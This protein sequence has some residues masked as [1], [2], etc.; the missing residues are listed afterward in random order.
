MVEP[1]E[2]TDEFFNN[3]KNSFR[4]RIG[5]IRHNN[6]LRQLLPS[7]FVSSISFEKKKT[8]I[9]NSLKKII[10][11]VLLMIFIATCH[12]SNAQ[13]G[14]NIFT[15]KGK[16]HDSLSGQVLARVTVAL[17]KDSSKVVQTVITGEDGSFVFTPIA[18]NEYFIKANAVGYNG[19]TVKIVLDKTFIIDLGNLVMTRKEGN[20]SEVVVTARKPLIKQEVD[21]LVY[22]L[23]SDPESKGNSLLEMMRKVPF[24]SEDGEG[25]IL[26]KGS[27][28]YKILINGKP[29]GMVDRNPTQVLRSIPASTIKSIEV[30]TSP[31]SKYDAEGLA[32]IINIITNKKIDNGYNGTVNIN[33]KP[34]TGGP[35][36]GTSF[37]I[38][39]GKL[40]LSTFGGFGH[41]R[42]PR[43]MGFYDRSTKGSDVISL[44]Q[45]IARESKSRYGYFGSEISYELD[46]LQLISAQFN[47][48]GY[49]HKGTS[50]QFSRLSEG[51]ALLQQYHLA[52][53][54]NSSGHAIDLAF[55]YQLGFKNRKDRLLTFSYRFTE[56]SHGQLNDLEFGNQFQ[57]DEADQSQ[58]NRGDIGEHTAQVDYVH[59]FKNGNM[60]TGVK[61]IFRNNYSN[62]AANAF[63]ESSGK[64]EPVISRTNQYQNI[65]NVL[66]AY[67]AYQYNVKTFS[68]KA[69]IRV[70]QTFVDADFKSTGTKVDQQY[71]NLI[72]SILINKTLKNKGTLNLS[73][74]NRI[75]RPTIY[76]LNPF[77]DRSNPQL[78]STGN[79]DLRPAY[80]NVVQLAYNRSKKATIN[81]AIGGMF[82]NKLITTASIYDDVANITRTSFQNV[83]DG[84][85]W[86][87][88]L[89][90]NYPVNKRWNININSDLRHLAFTG[91]IGKEWV[92]AEG[93]NG[94]AAITNNY[95]FDKG[96]RL[97]AGLTWNSGGIAGFQNKSNG[98]TSTYVGASK[99]FYKDKFNFSFSLSNPFSKFRTNREELMSSDFMQVQQSQLYFRSFSFSLNYRFGKLKEAVKK[100]KRGINNDDTSN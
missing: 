68:F 85:I 73:F 65:Q 98:Y 79:P 38:K 23:Q 11:E 57:Y 100:S 3:P 29:S 53:L 58:S 51:N 74:T 40:G 41:N 88:N 47:M 8:V 7:N 83:G 96:L 21:K 54:E 19:L 62:F 86:K 33:H 35:G 75:R 27:K 22:D 80:T 12:N 91:Q 78:E 24:L 82:F 52:N 61:A 77:V 39:K 67:Q 48:N 49:K 90:I 17:F 42:A 97:N 1:L 5:G 31:S 9:M 45:D 43:T 18:G 84:R 46:S 95:R 99:D 20:L 59:P 81:I 37:S 25:N 69:G 36:L 64:Y 66:A 15:V 32:G 76:Q 44:H 4:H 13:N 6:F 60:E 10:F 72:P 30:I 55:N 50:N 28:D 92:N 93:F 2:T 34:P 16:I 56:Q 14:Q 71:I 94:Y 89:F 70:E 63:N 87:T 26:L